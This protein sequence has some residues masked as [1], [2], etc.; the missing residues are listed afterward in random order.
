MTINSNKNNS[1][2]HHKEIRNALKIWKN[3]IRKSNSDS[4]NEIYLNFSMIERKLKAQNKIQTDL[5]KK[6]KEL[7][8]LRNDMKKYTRSLKKTCAIVSQ[9]MEKLH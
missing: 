3:K 8:F 7:D 9:H 2:P 5:L 1:L 6:E 4:K